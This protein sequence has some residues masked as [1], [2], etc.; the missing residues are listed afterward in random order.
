MQFAIPNSSSLLN[1]FWSLQL[2]LQENCLLCCKCWQTLNNVRQTR[3]RKKI[4]KCFIVSQ[5]N[6]RQVF[7]VSDIFIY[8][9]RTVGALKVITKAIQQ[10][11]KCVCWNTVQCMLFIEDRWN[12]CAFVIIQRIARH[13]ISESPS[14]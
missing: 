4:Q 11:W 8:K 2:N 12:N 6:E 1:Y 14:F 10:P 13:A 5:V 9:D 7:K 3:K